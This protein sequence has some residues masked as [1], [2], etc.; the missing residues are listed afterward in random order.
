MTEAF[1]HDKRLWTNKNSPQ[2]PLGVIINK[3]IKIKETIFKK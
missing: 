1:L 3:N 2:I